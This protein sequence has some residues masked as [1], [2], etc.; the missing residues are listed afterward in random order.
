MGKVIPNFLGVKGKEGNSTQRALML[1]YLILAVY[2]FKY[3][4]LDIR[5]RRMSQ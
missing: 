5:G 4:G 3:I 1:K 2:I